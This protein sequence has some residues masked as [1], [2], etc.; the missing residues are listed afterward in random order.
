LVIERDL[1]ISILK[2]T[3]NGPVIRESI[4]RDAKI[5]S[6]VASKML[7]KLQTDGLV[8]LEGDMIEASGGGRLKLAVRAVDLGADVE[9]MSNFLSWQ[10]FEDIAA[11]ALERDRYVVAKNVRFKHAERRW[12]IDVVGCR[13]PLVICIDCKHWHHGMHPSTLKKIVAAQN[14]CRRL[15]NPCQTCP[16]MS[17]APSGIEL[18]LSQLSCRLFE[19]PSNSTIMCPLY[20]CCSFETS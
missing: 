14:E 6:V 5:P 3:K 20:L 10:E 4:N 2:L 11:L 19:A 8:Y 13:K 15:L 7:R 18:K 9:H 12:E 16:L 17:S 1:L